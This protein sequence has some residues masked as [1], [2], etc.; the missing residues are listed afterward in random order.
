M[1]IFT[2]GNWK[3]NILSNELLSRD[4]TKY[5]KVQISAS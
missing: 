5:A 3:N 4:N 2:A 1:P